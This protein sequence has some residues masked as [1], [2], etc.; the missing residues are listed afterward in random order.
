MDSHFWQVY[1]HE[2]LEVTVVARKRKHP[3]T[4]FVRERYILEKICK[5]SFP[6]IHISWKKRSVNISR[7]ILI[8]KASK[9]KFL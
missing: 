8:P 5:I 2:Q 4:Y 1:C 7:F 6:S 3:K 9:R